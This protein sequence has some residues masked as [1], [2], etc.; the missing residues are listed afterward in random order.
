M[1]DEIR[2]T[3]IAL[4]AKHGTKKLSEAGTLFTE[5]FAAFGADREALL[6]IDP[7]KQ[8]K[9]SIRVQQDRIEKREQRYEKQSGASLKDNPRAQLSVALQHLW[10]SALFRNAADQL[11]KEKIQILYDLLV[12]RYV[13]GTPW[14]DPYTKHLEFLYPR[15]RDW[16]LFFFSYTNTGANRINTLFKETIQG[17]IDGKAAPVLLTE[18]ARRQNNLLAEIVFQQLNI[19]NV[20]RGYFDKRDIEAGQVLTDEIKEACAKSFLFIQLVT[21]ES[22]SFRVSNWPFDEY[23]LFKKANDDL[24]EQYKKYSP[25]LRN[26]FVFALAGGTLTE[27]QP[28]G[29]PPNDDYDDWYAHIGQV[30]HE[31]LTNDTMF[32]MA[33]RKI[34][35]SVRRFMNEDWLAVADQLDASGEAAGAQDVETV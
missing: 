22:L 32:S 20:Q 4:Y 31:T 29:G 1:P 26:R 21:T 9:E 14:P 33:I 11:Y 28:E 23:Q 10:S 19:N 8:L 6:A 34:A 16:Y 17:M 30:R 2:D 5:A 24:Q 15:I 27:V 12:A 3:L 7:Y 25:V 13:K 18:E 35:G